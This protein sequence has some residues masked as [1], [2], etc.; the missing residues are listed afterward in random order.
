MPCYFK[1]KRS[2]V[3]RPLVPEE[4][5][6]GVDTDPPRRYI[7]FLTGPTSCCTHRH[8]KKI[9]QSMLNTKMDILFYQIMFWEYVYFS[10]SSIFYQIQTA[11]FSPPTP[12]CPKHPGMGSLN[13]CL[14]IY[15]D[16]NNFKQ[17][18]LLEKIFFC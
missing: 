10:F 2:L 5:I 12:P 17:M 6:S 4:A 16:Y 1:T 14:D 18:E 11:E 13:F 15:N 3:L 9:P 8:L 7:L